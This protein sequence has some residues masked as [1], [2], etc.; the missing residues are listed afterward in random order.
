MIDIT[1]CTKFESY[2]KALVKY[3]EAFPAIKTSDI[4]T[5][6]NFIKKLKNYGFDVDKKASPPP[7]PAASLGTET[8]IGVPT[9]NT[10]ST[11]ITLPSSSTSTSN[12]NA[13]TIATPVPVPVSSTPSAAVRRGTVKK[14]PVIKRK[15]LPPGLKARIDEY[16][17]I[18]STL[19]PNSKIAMARITYECVL[20]YV[21][22]YTKSG[23]ILLKNSGHFGS[24][25]SRPPYTNFEEM[26]KKFIE[27]ITNTGLAQAFRSFEFDKMHQI[28]HNYHVS[29]KTID[30]D[31]I[32]NNLIILL[33]FMLQDVSDL[34][35]SLDVSKIK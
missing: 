24:A 21:V 3:I 25:Y 8:P 7:A 32:K 16:F 15:Q 18:D 30:A 6:K 29:G 34:L 26:N 2:I 23:T 22:E 12:S 19:M 5:D 1:D 31:Q 11:A 10:G 20:K 28:I 35:I 14:Y 4:D 13:S 17:D 27:L 9:T 33:E